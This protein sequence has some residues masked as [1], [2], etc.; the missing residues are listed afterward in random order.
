[1]ISEQMIHS[2]PSAEKPRFFNFDASAVRAVGSWDNPL[3]VGKDVCDALG[4]SKYRDALAQLDSDERVSRKVDTLG[5]PQEMACIT[6]SGLYFLVCHSRKPQARLFRRWV[7]GEVLPAIRKTGSY[8]A[9]VASPSADFPRPPGHGILA[10]LPRIGREALPD[11]ETEHTQRLLSTVIGEDAPHW[12]GRL[13][14]L[15]AL[16]VRDRLFFWRV[17]NA[18]D[19]GQLGSLGLALRRREG[20]AYCGHGLSRLRLSV[21][22]RARGRQYIITRDAISKP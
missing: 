18:A 22:G 9:P 15:A 7:T 5:G 6:E 19:P 10:S 1:M 14:A 20:I 16:A 13:T 17:R 11:L 3:F 8:Q 4:Y 21:V 2:A 12:A